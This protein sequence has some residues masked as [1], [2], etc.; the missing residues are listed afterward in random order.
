MQYLKSSFDLSLPTGLALES[1]F[2]PTHDRYDNNREVKMANIEDY[3][4]VYINFYTLVRNIFSVLEDKTLSKYLKVT[5]F[6]TIEFKNAIFSELETLR[7]LFEANKKEV[8]FYRPNYYI[9]KQ[10]SMRFTSEFWNMIEF[11]NSIEAQNVIEFPALVT[12][13]LPKGKIL[14]MSH[15]PFDLLQTEN[16]DLLRSTTGQILQKPD[17][18]RLFE[19]FGTNDMSFVPFTEVMLIIYG[20]GK[21]VSKLDEYK[22]HP[23]GIVFRTK[24]HAVLKYMNEKNELNSVSFKR[25]AKKTEVFSKTDMLK[26]H[27]KKWSDW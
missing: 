2:A 12:T 8:V 24:L 23:F 10:T 7:L 21:M 26:T 6:Y 14:I 27:T 18:Y 20:D 16:V 1:L 19:K 25:A 17:F 4:Y 13:N 3:D 15:F 11:S 22:T 9:L 5:K